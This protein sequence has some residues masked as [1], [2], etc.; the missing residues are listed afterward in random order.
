MVIKHCFVY[1]QTG[2]LSRGLTP[3]QFTYSLSD[4]CCWCHVDFH[5]FIS[6]SSNTSIELMIAK[7][8]NTPT[9][10]LNDPSKNA[11][12]GM[13]PRIINTNPWK[14]ASSRVLVCSVSV[15]S[16]I[17]QTTVIMCS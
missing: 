5:C 16:L 6:K 9:S 12:T 3:G 1:K 14:L 10:N 15:F 8:S 17:I 11:A 13:N 4:R 7:I 2:R